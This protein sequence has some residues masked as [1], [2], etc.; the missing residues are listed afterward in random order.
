MAGHSRQVSDRSLA[1]MS[2]Q[3]GTEAAGKPDALQVRVQ[4]SP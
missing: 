3:T 4:D 1:G 2:L